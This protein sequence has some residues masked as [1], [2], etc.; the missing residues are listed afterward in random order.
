MTS[1]N[2]NV[3]PMYHVEFSITNTKAI[4]QKEI[5]LRNKQKTTHK[6][7][8]KQVVFKSSSYPII[9]YI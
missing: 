8:I 6:C 7:R 4:F 9:S 2:N 1:A 3:M 5:I